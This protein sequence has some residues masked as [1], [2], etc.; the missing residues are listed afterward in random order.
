MLIYTHYSHLDEI[1]TGIQETPVN[2]K[3]NVNR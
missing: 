3:D 1:V 2:Q